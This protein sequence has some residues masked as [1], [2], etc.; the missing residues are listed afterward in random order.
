VSEHSGLV[1]FGALAWSGSWRITIRQDEFKQVKVV[2]GF[3]PFDFGYKLDPGKTLGTPVFYGGLAQ[4]GFQEMSRLESDFQLRSV[5][6]QAP[7]PRLRPVLYNSWEATQFNFDEK[8]QEQLADKAASIGVERFVMDDGWFSTRVKDNAGL[9]DW[10]PNPQRFPNGLK[11]LIDHVHSLGMDFGLWVEPEM[12]NENSDLY[13][14]HP[15]WILHFN[16]RPRTQARNQFVLNLAMPEVQDYIL[17]FLDKLLRENDIAFLKWDANRNF[18]EPGW[19]Q[20]PPDEQK[21]IWVAYTEGYY[22]VLRTLRQRFPKLEIESCSGGGGRVDLGVMHYTDEVWPSDNTDPFDRLIIQDGFTYAYTPAVMMAWVTDSPNW[23]NG[24]STSL[25]YRFLSAMQGSLGIGANLTKWTPDDFA[26]AKQLVSD[27]KI[28]RPLVQQGV[29]Y[30]LISPADGNNLS[31]TESVSQDRS[32]AVV[33]AFLHS[34][35]FRSL[36]PPIRVQGLNP[37]AIY[38]VR[39]IGGKLGPDTPQRASGAYFMHQG[40]DFKLAGDYD[41]RAAL[42]TQSK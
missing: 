23:F 33:F 21:K 1:W 15:D 7:K 11:P 26:T 13:R 35:Q 34:Q 28:V 16:G 30:R 37:A 39:S 29:L 4:H 25:T 38:T 41:A 6:P 18:S 10:Y 24:R 32:S 22:R 27:Y 40:I 17:G 2:G 19:E 14:K 8:T 5:L 12:V 9:G 31:A 42:L 3:N 36:A 20:V